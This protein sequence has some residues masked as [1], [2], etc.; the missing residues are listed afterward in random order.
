M[1]GR[2]AIILISRKAGRPDDMAHAINFAC[3]Q[4]EDHLGAHLPIG[5]RYDTSRIALS[6][7]EE[8]EIV[9]GP[10]GD[11]D[12][13]QDAISANCAVIEPDYDYDF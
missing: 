10:R 5:R 7:E 9:Y 2:D 3:C 1:R 11:F 12:R 4:L 13:F 6:E 8:D